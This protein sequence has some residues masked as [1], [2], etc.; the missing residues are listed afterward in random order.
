MIFDAKNFFRGKVTIIFLVAKKKRMR[1]EF[2]SDCKKK[3]LVP[4]KSS[5][6]KIFFLYI[7]N[8][9]LVITNRF[10]ECNNAV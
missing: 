4:R 8:N 7:K 2:F 5:C 1:Q 3:I 9:F 10:F 6:G